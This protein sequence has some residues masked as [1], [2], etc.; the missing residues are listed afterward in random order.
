MAVTVFRS[1]DSGAPILT[2]QAGSLFNLLNACLVRGYAATRATGTITQAGQPLNNETVT[3]DGTVYTFKT[4][5]TPAAG[6]VFIGASA[7]IT[8]VNLLNA[9][10][11][12]GVPNTNYG[13]GTTHQTNLGTT[14]AT[15]TVLTL[16]AHAGGV[17]GN[18]ITLATTATN[19]TVSG[20]TLTGGAGT[21]TTASAGWSL[22]GTVT[23]V[24]QG[25]FRGATGVRHYLEVNDNSPG[26]GYGKEARLRGYETYTGTFGGGATPFPT[27][28][29]LAN[30]VFWRKSAT[31]DAAPRAWKM[32]ANGRLFHLFI[33]SGDSGNYFTM[34]WGEF[35]S[36]L[37]GDL[38][39]T[40]ITGRTTE[41]SNSTASSIELPSYIGASSQTQ[42][43]PGGHFVARGYS[44]AGSSVSVGKHGDVGF[45]ASSAGT[46]LAPL[47]LIA[48][49]NPVDG[50]LYMSP[51]RI[52]DPTTAPAPN[53]RG[54][55]TGLFHG[56]HAFASFTDGDTFSGLAGSAYASRTFEVVKS[57]AAN[58]GYW[59][60]ETSDWGVS[61]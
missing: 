29:Q 11:G 17:G 51:V 8:L 30:G 24:N 49:P 38:Y 23:G 47:G 27:V 57:V 53:I 9:M 59:I 39:R 61:A 43:A 7:A 33:N 34:S 3:V 6:E 15:A 60:L 2:G 54:E 13:T 50:G 5:L 52:L 45:F 1:T 19:Y 20:A 41:N 55:I 36:Y 21:D 48:Y 56:G 18:A 40:L 10:H 44:G 42:N 31:L 35:Y 14:T 25:A 4:A 46:T 37:T 16:T 22:T 32:F 58:T 26:A 28:A 12:M